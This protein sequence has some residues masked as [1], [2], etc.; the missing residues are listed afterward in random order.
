MLTT[1]WYPWLLLAFGVIALVAVVWSWTTMRASRRDR[2]IQAFLD[3]ADALERDLQECKKRMQEIQGWVSTL[4]NEGSQR[5]S[6]ALNADASVQTALKLVLSQRLWLRDS[7]HSASLHQIVAAEAHLGR[8]RQSLSEHMNKLESMRVELE[9][10]SDSLDDAHRSARV[11][12][13]VSNA[14]H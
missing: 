14:V 8:S 10:A 7:L 9:R 11:V 13:P 12:L 6:L 2:A 3:A 5:A 1:A 4:P